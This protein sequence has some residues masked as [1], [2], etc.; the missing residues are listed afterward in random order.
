[1]MQVP[2]CREKMRNM[3]RK[4]VALISAVVFVIAGCGKNGETV[5]MK[6]GDTATQATDK[7]A[8]KPVA[9][10]V[11]TTFAGN[12][13]NS[14]NYRKFCH[15]WQ[16]ETG[17]TIIDRSSLTDETFKTRVVNDFATGSEPD[18]LFFFI[19]ADANSFIEA[20]MV[21]SLDEIWEV[22]PD[23]ASN[24]DVERIPTSMV[25]GKI[26]AIPVN[27]YWEA[28]FVNTTVLEAAGVEMPDDDYRWE[29]FLADCEQIKN[30]GYI[31]IAAAL[32][33]IP[34]YWWE[35]AIFNHTTPET[36]G[37]IPG[38]VEDQIG[39][40]WVAAMED[41][42]FLYE[43]GYFPYNTDTATDDETF[44][45]FLNGEAAFLIDGSWR[46]GSIVQNCQTDPLNPATLDEEQLNQFSVTYVPGTDTRKATDMIGGMSMGYYITRS[47]WEDPD[48]RA[49]AISFV[50]YMTSDDVVPSFVQH[51]THALKNMTAIET[52][53]YNSLQVTAID[54]LS[55]CTSLTGAV[56]DI[57]Q[58][59][60]RESAFDDMP[61]IVTGRISAEDAVREGLERYQAEQ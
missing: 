28:M 15:V 26:Y 20:D 29:Q 6:E 57:F 21:V 52:E 58:G 10:E 25:D 44:S 34:H 33:N 32:G 47:A 24:L 50:S 51:T 22:Y 14:E 38:S 37:T 31:P 1:M 27:G 39:Q 61:K 13:G 49:A 43:A 5:T 4:L 23:F 11:V 19:G 7:S 36:H 30:A 48:T 60:C 35:Y 55:R 18:V 54:M 8:A 2:L 3:K 41:I 59:E 53:N 42:K 56:Q 16:N 17:N 46:V 9:L 40:S 12:D 45:M